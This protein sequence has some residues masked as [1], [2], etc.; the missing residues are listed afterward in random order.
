MFSKFRRG[1]GFIG[2]RDL[3]VKDYGLRFRI[4]LFV[5]CRPQTALS[6]ETVGMT[7]PKHEFY[8]PLKLNRYISA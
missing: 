2:F 5:F 7:S 8:T 4:L 6:T 3:G 1:L